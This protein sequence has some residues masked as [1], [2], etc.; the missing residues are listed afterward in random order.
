VVF[1]KSVL[2]VC[3]SGEQ[4]GGNYSCNALSA[5]GEGTAHQESFHINVQ[6]PI[7]SCEWLHNSGV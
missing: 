2:E 3:V 1:I 6:P 7:H 5:D 4:V